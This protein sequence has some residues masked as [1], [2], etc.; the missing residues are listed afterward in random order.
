[1]GWSMASVSFRMAG[2]G[3]WQN[4]LPNEELRHLYA[5][6]Y[7]HGLPIS[8]VDKRF[9]NA[10]A[11]W[12]AAG[13]AVTRDQSLLPLGP[14]MTNH[15]LEILAPWFQDMSGCM[16][17]AVHRYL[18]EYRLFAE[19]FCGRSKAQ[20]A[21]VGNLVTIL[22]CAEALDIEAFHLLRRR[23]IG[24]HPPRGP[25][26]RFFF[27][28]YAFSD[29]PKRIFG[30]TTYGRGEEVH[31]SVIRSRGLE[32]GRL[33]SLLRE[34][35]TMTYLSALCRHESAEPLEGWCTG[36]AKEMIGSLREVGLLEPDDPPRLAIPVLKQRDM[37][38]TASLHRKVSEQIN[39]DFTA[40]L[41]RLRALVVQCSFSRCSLPDVLSMLFH[42]AY[43][44][45][46]DALV[47]EGVVPDFPDR[48]GGEWGAWLRMMGS[49][50][51]N[52]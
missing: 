4:L 20:A 51:T 29:G 40:G 33:P 39:Y 41:S 52:H 50:V 45:A 31:L 47:R 36:Y 34:Q 3:D 10:V 42:V 30:V 16:C 17:D 11:G 35:S 26:G 13:I 7:P 22:T 14:I 18:A 1:M 5:G 44:Y 25:A 9:T 49:E 23:L 2:S 43:S 46:A 32:R 37:E 6:I 38:T 12:E 27:W 21:G 15:D 48:A 8:S 19:G 28:G 24:P